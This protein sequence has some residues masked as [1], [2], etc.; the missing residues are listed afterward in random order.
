MWLPFWLQ[1]FN[2]RWCVFVAEADPLLHT[3]RI[4]LPYLTPRRT[5][6]IG[7]LNVA[8]PGEELTWLDRCSWNTTTVTVFTRTLQW[9]PVLGKM[10]SVHTHAITNPKIVFHTCIGVYTSIMFA[11]CP[12]HVSLCVITAVIVGKSQKIRSSLFLRLFSFRSLSFSL[13]GPGLLLYSLF[14][15]TT[16]PLPWMWD[17]THDNSMNNRTFII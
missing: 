2:W 6:I 15:G 1:I 13:L 14:S 7:R 17:T 11:T 16:C 10:N 5:F 8:Q 4:F 12:V 9:F 3:S